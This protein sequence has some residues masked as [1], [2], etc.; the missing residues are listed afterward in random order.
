MK[1][2]HQH[3]FAHFGTEQKL[4][5]C[6]ECSQLEAEHP[7]PPMT[8]PLGAHWLQPKREEIE[9]DATHA[10]MKRSAFVKLSEYSS[11]VPSGVYP[12]KM[13]KRFS[14]RPVC[15]IDD[16]VIE[17]GWILCWYGP[18]YPEGHEWYGSASNEYRAI[19]LVD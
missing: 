13:W 5:R 19:L 15:T 11:S 14:D 8:D 12:G 6:V 10:V 3:N 9:I 4:R 2:A 17:K 7:I 1:A 16:K 18:L